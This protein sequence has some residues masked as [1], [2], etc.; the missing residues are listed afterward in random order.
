MVKVFN[1]NRRR[2]NYGMDGLAAPL[3]NSP[4]VLGPVDKLARIMLRGLRGEIGLMPSMGMLNDKEVADILTISVGVGGMGS[5]R[6]RPKQ[7]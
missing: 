5:D 6:S 7:W 2:P 1:G 3:Q 4:R